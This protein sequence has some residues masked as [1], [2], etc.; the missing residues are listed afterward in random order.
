MLLRVLSELVHFCG[1][2]SKNPSSISYR[3]FCKAYMLR[4]PE[5]PIKGHDWHLVITNTNG[6][7]T[8]L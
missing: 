3:H 4:I 7:F 8:G 5:H 2:T 6:N 1:T